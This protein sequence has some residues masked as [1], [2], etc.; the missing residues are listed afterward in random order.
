MR[1][2]YVT[3]QLYRAGPR[4][5]VITWRD[6]SITTYSARA[7]VLLEH[8]PLRVRGRLFRTTSNGT[9]A[10]EAPMLVPQS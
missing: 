1:A 10:Y 5:V 8:Q 6:G 4:G 3:G 7:L 9:L 2:G